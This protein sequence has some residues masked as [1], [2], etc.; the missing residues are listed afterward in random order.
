MSGMTPVMIR[1][2]P[3]SAVLVGFLLALLATLLAPAAPASAHAVL[4]SSSPRADSLLPAAPSE[5]VLTFSE[6]VREVPGKI[7]VIG[8]D[9]KRA[10]RGEP[11]FDGT[12]V[13]IT[14]DQGAPLGTYLVSYRVISADSHP[15]AGGY[16]YS[17]GAPSAAPSGS[18]TAS[19]VDVTVTTA[20]AVT[21]FLG[22]AG[23]VLLVGPVLV[24]TLLWPRRLSRRGPAR[25]VWTGVGLIALSTLAGLWLQVPYTAGG[26]FFDVDPGG[27]GTVLSSPFGTAQL[28]RFGILLAASLLL[29]PVLAGTEGRADRPLLAILALAGLATWPLAGHPAASPVPAVSVVVDIVHLASMAVWLGGLLMLVVF[30]LRRADEREL[31]AIL[32]IWSRW[33][34]LAVTALL[35]AG[36]V[37]ALIEV[38]TLGALT[39]TT[40]GRLIIAKIA[41]FALVIAVAAYSRQL[42]VRRS[43]TD[44]P[45]RMRRA[46]WGELGVTAIVLAVSSA[47]VQA[48]PARTAVANEQRQGP[49]Y[50]ST[51]LTSNLYSL[52]V[53]IDPAKRG[54]NS[55]HLYA[56]TPDNK[57]MP[58]VE[59]K[60]T[61][62]L[63]ASGVEPIDVPL[64]PLTDNHVTGEINLPTAGGWQFRFTVRTSDVDQATV[65][66]TV[67]IT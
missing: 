6:S 7:R 64:L 50:F 25:L 16:T 38:G 62:A 19:N 66:A 55:I 58:V 45:G 56:F 23:L 41:L 65:T 40:Y 26:R 53:E 21:K 31:A 44:R 42:V 10:D 2:A 61:A 14:V 36:T 39:S 28:V 47:L 1:W 48:T 32:P 51:T 35:L 34:T 13:T 12:A 5:V 3:R 37:Q 33:A 30:L 60:I 49:G 18:E 11:T 59:W 29:R 27:L 8:P 22:Y 63:P 9:G 52:Q 43:A 67:P 17:V 46:V 15:V 54:N 57:P 24:L 20:I 4:A